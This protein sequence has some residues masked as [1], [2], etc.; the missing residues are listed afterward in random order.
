MRAQ[1]SSKVLMIRPANFGFNSETAA[2]NVFQHPSEGND[3]QAK[4]LEEFD[5]MVEILRSEGVDVW[6]ENDNP[7][8]VCPDAI[9]PNNCLGIHPEKHL[10]LYPML[11][12]NRRLERNKALIKHIQEKLP[13]H[14]L[15]DLSDA[16]KQGKFLEGTG[17]LVFDHIRKVVY[18]SKSER[19]NEELV[20][21]LAQLLGYRPFV[22]DALDEHGIPYYHTNVLLTIGTRFSIVC[23]ECIPESQR[24]AV[25]DSLFEGNRPVLLISRAQVNAFAGNMLELKNSADE[26]LLVLSNT[27]L[28]SLEASEIAFL[29]QFA[30]LLP[31]E[32]PS[33]ERIGGGSVRCMMA[34]VF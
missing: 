10:V 34:E 11:A 24:N 28:S 22:F 30:L 2:S 18:A 17:S 16:E 25:L 9:F 4:A 5:A 3:S 8:V 7:D 6:V 21:N 23:A 32:I 1:S 13:Q 14:Q 20:L 19:T 15:S 27:A 26:T 31:I 12:E 33:I 29:Q